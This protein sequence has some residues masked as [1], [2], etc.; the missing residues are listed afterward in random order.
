MARGHDVKINHR[1]SCDTSWE[2]KRSI[3]LKDW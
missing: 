2:G 3:Y 1:C